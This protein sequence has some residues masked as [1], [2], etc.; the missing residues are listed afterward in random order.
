MKKLFISVLAIASLVACNTEE[1]LVQQGPQAIGFENAFVDNATRANEAV[2]P[3]TTTSSLTAFDVWAFMDE[4]KGI[5]F[6]G[7]DVTG[8]KGNFSYAN[9]QY[10][11]PG[12]DYYFAALAPMNSKNWSL[13]T[14]DASKDGAG[15]VT[16][17]NVNGTE[18]LLYAAT[19]VS[20]KNMNPDATM[21]AVKFQF[22]HLLSK[23]K[24]TFK[25][26][27]TNNNAYIDVKNVTLTAPKKAS[28]NLAQA[29]WWSANEWVLDA[30][31]ET[32]ALKFGDACAKTAPAVSQVAAEERLTIPADANVEYT[33]TFDVQLYMG[34][35][36][37]FSEPQTLT[38]TI[39]GVALEMGKAYNFSAEINASNI[40]ENGVALQPIVFDVN[41]VKEWIEAGEQTGVI[42]GNVENMTMF[43]DAKATATVNLAGTL[44]G[45]GHTLAADA[46]ADYFMSNTARLINA[47][48]DATVRNLTIDGGN[49]AIE[50]NGESYGIRA[51][52]LN[53]AGEFNV[54]NVVIRNV[55]YP[56][57][58]DSKAKT[59]NVVNSTLEGWTSYNAST[60]ATFENVSFEINTVNG[61]GR[62][63]PYAT[64]TFRNC[65][66]EDGFVID[67]KYV[68]GDVK[69][70]GCTYAGRPLTCAD[71]TD[72]GNN[73]HVE[74]TV[75]E[76]PASEF[77][78]QNVNNVENM[79]IDG[80]NFWTRGIYITKEGEYTVNNVVVRNVIYALN[81]N[82]TKSVKLAV[83]NSTLEGWTS[84]GA[85]T[86][87]TFTNVKFECGEYANFKPQ[88]STTLTNCSF[89]NG[90]M[91]DFTALKN[92]VIT[93][94]KC[95][96]N[97]ELIT[98]ENFAEVVRV[99][100]GDFTN[101]IAF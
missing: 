34:D 7:E 49:Y 83:S 44:D 16:F 9:I 68:T 100:D 71:L 5:V 77:L 32:V 50:K 63:R 20:T 54:D 12:H 92:G 26:G 24:F 28:I 31:K 21:D 70:E 84:F 27:F 91:I 64:T 37:A 51:L 66:F 82:T 60:V 101:K 36:P 78:V 14:A 3:S 8:E 38:S 65:A 23:V 30:N 15:E 53:G 6:E 74:L 11:I 75:T 61:L 80:G 48:A 2:D 59:L 4:P 40:S 1:V 67:L 17:T 19:M 94:D 62:V 90:F 76:K 85:S 56:I 73:V 93:F 46:A 97:G 72:A 41:E 96:Y 89:E 47:T 45:A 99:I 13:D 55:T 43:A 95:T 81:V 35:V 88:A 33:V 98:A 86:D 22:N 29:D 69:F 58:D 25:N 18:D 87:A 39:K 42:G 10:W 52:F 79:T 57:N